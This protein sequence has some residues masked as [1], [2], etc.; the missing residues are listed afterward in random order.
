MS[1]QEI[2]VLRKS[3]RYRLHDHSESLFLLQYISKESEI[4]DS[5][6]RFNVSIENGLERLLRQNDL[7]SEI[8]PNVE[9]SIV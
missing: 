5:V 8:K 9:T 1:S 2:S 7:V 6:I 4:A 3:L